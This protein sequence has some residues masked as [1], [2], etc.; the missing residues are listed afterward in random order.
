[1]ALT[2]MPA[3]PVTLEPFSTRPDAVVALL[4]VVIA[5]PS[6]IAPEKP[7]EAAIATATP[8]ATASSV[9]FVSASTVTVPVAVIVAPS[10][11]A[12]TISLTSLRATDTDAAIPSAKLA[13]AAI[14]MLT[15]TAVVS[16]VAV[17]VALTM[18]FAPETVLPVPTDALTVS[19]I[20]FVAAEPEPAKLIEIADTATLI[21]AATGVAVIED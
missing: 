15:A 1:M 14:E 17:S 2:V 9:G 12:L 5:P 4:F 3:G 20:V 11:I 19:P 16:I 13:P 8:T 21:E 10:T 6:A 7:P 18:T